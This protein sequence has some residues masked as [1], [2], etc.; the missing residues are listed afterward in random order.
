MTKSQEKI[1]HYAMELKK[2]NPVKPLKEYVE[3]ITLAMKGIK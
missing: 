3:E 2:I 1:L